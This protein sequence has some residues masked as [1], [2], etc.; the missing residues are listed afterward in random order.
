MTRQLKVALASVNGSGEG[1][2]LGAT[3]VPAAAAAE[4]AA[5][6][7]GFCTTV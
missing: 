7:C 5:R 6:K 2:E 4:A 3:T 1:R